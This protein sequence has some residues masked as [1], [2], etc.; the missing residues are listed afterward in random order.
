[1]RFGNRWAEISKM[2]N[3]R[4]DNAIKNHWNSSMK[5]KIEKH[6]ER[7]RTDSSIPIIDKTGRFIIRNEDIEGCLK[8]LQQSGANSK[9][10]KNQSK[11]YTGRPLGTSSDAGHMHSNRMVS[12]PTPMSAVQNSVAYNSMMKRQYDNM[13]GSTF[14]GLGY[15]PQSVKRMKSTLDYS[16][17]PKNVS[18]SPPSKKAIDDFL[19]DL[20]GG[21][22]KG[23]YYSA[24]ERRR[25]VEKAVKSGSCDELNTLGLST[26]EYNRLQKI[27]PQ[28][29]KQRHYSVPKWA[30]PQQQFHLHHPHYGSGYLAPP[31]NVQWAHPSPL[32]PMAQPF[33]GYPPIPPPPLPHRTRHFRDTSRLL[34]TENPTNT[35]QSSSLS[36]A[37]SNDANKF[38]RLQ[39]SINLKHSP[40]LRTK[41]STSQKGKFYMIFWNSSSINSY[42]VGL[43]RTWYPEFQTILVIETK[44]KEHFESCSTSDI[45]ENFAEYPL[46]ATPSA[47]KTSRHGENNYFSP[48][49]LPTPKQTSTP[50]LC[51]SWG[52]DDAKLLEETFAKGYTICSSS[53]NKSGLEQPSRVCFKDQLSEDNDLRNDGDL[54][55]KNEKEETPFRSVMTTTPGRTKS[56]IG[57]VTGS[58]PGR[59]RGN[60]AVVDDR[61]NLL[62]TAI[63]A[64][65]RSPKIGSVQDID[66]SLHHIDAYSMT[67][68]PL[69][70]GSPIMK[71]AARSPLRM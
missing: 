16:N 12:L 9:S 39:N 66:Q 15:T 20:K 23:V 44:S 28:I 38:P 34:P 17:T 54:L 57:L 8:A 32:Y 2:L 70:F 27:L 26:S 50:G 11:S 55:C 19:N 25:I 45:G 51:T 40:L 62:S 56:S 6:L 48:F 53:S 69:N 52:G 35:E 61:D 42:R 14:S 58:G 64:T 18:A 31:H 47:T 49:L 41:D 5:K 29:S 22:M 60:A 30:T 4:T 7:Q 21:Y 46:L 10:L 59:S 71:A 68:S 13:M 3:G 43:I 65:P 24:L 67:K 36:K 33:P 63:L 1:M 37:S